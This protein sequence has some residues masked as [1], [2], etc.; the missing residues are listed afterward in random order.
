[1]TKRLLGLLSAASRVHAT[2]SL[3]AAAAL[4]PSPGSLRLSSH[5][6]Q[7]KE[8]EKGFLPHQFTRTARSRRGVG[9]AGHVQRPATS[10]MFG[11]AKA[12]R[13]AG[14]QASK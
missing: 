6:P 10:A 9:Q 3:S 12:S 8:K 11:S 13:Q 1:M 7:A 14:K 2:S 4:L 5:L